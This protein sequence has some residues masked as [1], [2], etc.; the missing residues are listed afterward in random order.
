M[1]QIH[2]KSGRRRRGL[3]AL[4]AVIVAIVAGGCQMPAAARPTSPT[5][6]PCADRLHDF[7]GRLLLYDSLHHQLPPT[8]GDLQAV[9]PEPMP[10]P[11]CPTT[12]QPYVYNRAGLPIPGRDGL[13]VLYDAVPVSGMRWCVMVEAVKPGEP[14]TARV[15]P[16]PDLPAFSAGVVPSPRLPAMEPPPKR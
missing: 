13:A 5:I 4:A 9:D 2:A 10:P 3:A 6:D 1:T 14:L 15:I 7:C 11:V 8:L 16:L 12:G